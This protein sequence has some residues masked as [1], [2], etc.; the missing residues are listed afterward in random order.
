MKPS[1]RTWFAD[2]GM[3][4]VLLLLC[5]FFSAIT[6]SDQSPVGAEAAAMVLGKVRGL[7]LPANATVLVA[8]PGAAAPVALRNDGLVPDATA[9]DG[10]YSAN[11]TLP[12][13]AAEVALK[14]SIT[15]QIG[16]A[17]V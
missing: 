9:G 13:A 8:V 3:V 12:A 16:R 15:A 4:F 1:P 2:Y 7:G 10:V 5:A 11:L 14:F 17:H 6:V